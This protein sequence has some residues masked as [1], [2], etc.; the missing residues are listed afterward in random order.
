MA[1]L[2][3]VTWPVLVLCRD[4]GRVTLH[5]DHASTDANDLVLVDH[6]AKVLVTLHVVA[7]VGQAAHHHV[8]RLASRPLRHDTVHS[9]LHDDV[10]L[11][12]DGHISIVT[13]VLARVAT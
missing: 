13:V 6:L 3:Q 8:G 1:V 9:A 4:F 7:L 2:L 11:F 10:V 12:D 5:P